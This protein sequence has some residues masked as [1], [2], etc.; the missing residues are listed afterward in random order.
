MDA[1][2][3]SS[4]T[5]RP[6]GTAAIPCKICNA[7][8]PLYGVV[9]FHKCC[10]EVRGFRLPL[11]AIPV[12]YR[13]CASCGFLFTDAFDDWNDAAFKAHIYND[14]YRLVDPDYADQRPR[15]HAEL[16]NALWA[17]VKAETRL[18]DYG[19]GNDTLCAILRA[20]GFAA[21]VPYDPMVPQYAARPAGKFDL[22]TCIETFEHLPD[23]AA[24]VATI[25]DCTAD[26]GLVLHSTLLQPANLSEGVGWWY[27]APRNGHVSIFSKQALTILWARHGYKTVTLG[28]HLHLAFRTLPSYLAHLQGLVDAAL[29]EEKRPPPPIRATAA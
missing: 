15:A 27:V 4:F 22:V 2:P 29:A 1:M 17:A 24:G 12:Y 9:D 20:N 18:L 13:R 23:P 26:P 19:A 25:V 16:V 10:E 5:L 6:A 3:T 28:D 21:A 14:D 7:D 8:A 11:S